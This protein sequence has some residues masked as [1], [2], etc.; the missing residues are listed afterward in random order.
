MYIFLLVNVFKIW[1]S[2]FMFVYMYYKVKFIHVNEFFKV[3]QATNMAV[4]S[5]TSH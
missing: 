4:Q 1:Y 2:G 3:K 5:E